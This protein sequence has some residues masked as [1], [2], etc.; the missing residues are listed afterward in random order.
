LHHGRIYGHGQF[1]F[2]SA[3]FLGGPVEIPHCS[4]RLIKSVLMSN[5]NAIFSGSSH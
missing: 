2:A 4:L 1:A 3:F 5:A